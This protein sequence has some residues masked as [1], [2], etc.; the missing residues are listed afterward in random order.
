MSFGVAPRKVPIPRRLPDHSMHF[1]AYRALFTEDFAYHAG[2]VTWGLQEMVSASALFFTPNVRKVRLRF[3]CGCP[4]PPGERRDLIL[5]R[6]RV[7]LHVASSGEPMVTHEDGHRFFVRRD[8]AAASG[9]RIYRWE[10]PGLIG[11]HRPNVAGTIGRPKSVRRLG[12]H[13][14]AQRAR[15]AFLRRRNRRSEVHSARGG[16]E[17]PAPNIGTGSPDPT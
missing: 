5:D 17:L 14:L 13:P 4:V 1:S 10:S 2:W 16:G 11:L 15:R 8:S 6:M 12:A 3:P 9:Y 7:D